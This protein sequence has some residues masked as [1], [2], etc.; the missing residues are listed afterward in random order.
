MDLRLLFTLFA[1]CWVKIGGSDTLHIGVLLEKT[2]YWYSPFARTFE[3][4]FNY[5]FKEIKNTTGIL[6]GF[7]FQLHIR[8]TM[9]GLL[10]YVIVLLYSFFGKVKK[11]DVKC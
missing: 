7:D 8:N 6:D 10:L 11:M 9:V 5:V 1:L 2:N 4:V 3:Y